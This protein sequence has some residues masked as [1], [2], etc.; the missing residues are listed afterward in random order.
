MKTQTVILNGIIRFVLSY[1]GCLLF[2]F[3]IYQFHLFDIDA[4][5]FDYVHFGALAAIFFTLLQSMSSRNAI[6]AYFVLCVISQAIFPKHYDLSFSLVWNSTEH[7]LL[8]LAIYLFWKFPYAK[9]KSWLVRPMFLAVFVIIAWILLSLALRVYT[10]YYTGFMRLIYYDLH[11]GLLFGLGL[12][13]GIEV[14]DK[15]LNRKSGE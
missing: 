11:F 15:L 12:G 9:Q 2:G 10:N 8:G 6:A 7:I 13:V 1:F 5:A 4:P 14:G 3:L